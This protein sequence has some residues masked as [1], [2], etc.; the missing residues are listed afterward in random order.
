MFGGFF[1]ALT[2]SPNNNRQRMIPLSSIRRYALISFSISSMI[3]AKIA[4]L[5]LLKKSHQG[6]SPFH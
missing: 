6:K 1:G 3:E 2:P 4:P 5:T